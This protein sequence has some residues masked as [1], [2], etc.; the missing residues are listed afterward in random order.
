MSHKNNKEYLTASIY[1]LIGNI[2][3]QGVVLLSSGIFTRMM[4]RNDYGLVNT[5]SA[6]VLVLNTFIGLNLF[7]TLR[8]AYIDYREQYEEYKSSILLLSFIAF[9]VFTGVIMGAVFLLGIQ[10]DAFAVGLAALQAISLHTINYQMAAFSMENRYRLRTLLLILPNLVHTLLSIVFIAVCSHHPFYAKI[11]GNALGLLIFALFIMAA[12]FKNR[13]PQYIA[14]FW[15]YALWISVPAVF[16]T[17]SDLIL[18][19]SD[20][21]M[22]TELSGADETAVYSLVYNIGYI[23]VALYTAINGAWT[24]WFY[25]NAALDNKDEIKKIQR[26]YLAGFTLLTNGLLTVSPEI[27]KILSPETY[28]NGIDYVSLIV[29]ASFLI[30]VYSFFTTYLMYLKKTGI[31]ARNTIIAAV[32]NIALNY[33]LIPQYHAVGAAMATILSYTVLFFLYWM[34]VR[35]QGNGFFCKREMCACI[36][37]TVLY[38]AEFYF[39]RDNWLVRYALV[40]A[41]LLITGGILYKYYLKKD[42]GGKH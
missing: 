30:F 21:I 28:W 1:Y 15:K 3:G 23:I 6:W 31:I 8:N 24:P 33:T 11:S 39:I 32:L 40:L 22:L 19:Q 18:I 4:S 26:I 29:I 20:R 5:Y 37:I 14:E 10:T 7:I 17:L 36:G 42:Q 38:G 35:K 9:L 25:K 41:V 13:R 16:H 12:L 34:S 2:A 27:I